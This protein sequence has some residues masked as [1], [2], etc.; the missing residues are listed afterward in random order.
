MAFLALDSCVP[1]QCGVAKKGAGAS[2]VYDFAAVKVMVPSCFWYVLVLFFSALVFVSS[3]PLC[4]FSF[5]GA[6]PSLNNS[7]N[8]FASTCLYT[9]GPLQRLAT[10]ENFTVT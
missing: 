10:N 4:H 3:A 7:S 6:Q 9:N 2:S 8:D 1:S 5:P